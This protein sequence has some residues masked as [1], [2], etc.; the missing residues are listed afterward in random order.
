MKLYLSKFNVF[1]FL[2]VC[3]VRD[4][5][6]Y[7]RVREVDQPYSLNHFHSLTDFKSLF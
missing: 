5:D 2:Y 6:D 4:T 7:R 1:F 3:S